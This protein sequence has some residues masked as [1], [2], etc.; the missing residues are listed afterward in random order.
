MEKFISD[1]NVKEFVEKSFVTGFQMMHKCPI[2]VIFIKENNRMFPPLVVPYDWDESKFFQYIQFCLNEIPESQKPRAL[3]IASLTM[4]IKIK[5]E[6]GEKFQ[7]A[8]EEGDR[9]LLNSVKK[10]PQLTIFFQTRN[11][12]NNEVISY[13]ILKNKELGKRQ[14]INY[15]RGE[16][17]TN[18]D[19]RW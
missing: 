11:G 9:E 13:N 18:V 16:A 14:H 15:K 3:V 2:T 7:K 12:N 10:Q 5:R 19:F 17:K 6:E 1:K 4:K 8:I